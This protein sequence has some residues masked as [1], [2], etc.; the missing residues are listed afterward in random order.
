M[1]LVRLG[2]FVA[3]RAISLAK[4]LAYFG[5]LRAIMYEGTGGALRTTA[6]TREILAYLAHCV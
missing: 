5:G 3:P 6:A 4:P 2:T 1:T